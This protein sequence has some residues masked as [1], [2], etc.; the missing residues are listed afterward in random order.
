[1]SAKPEQSPVF[2]DHALRNQQQ[3][4]LL[5]AEREGKFEDLRHDPQG[6]GFAEEGDSE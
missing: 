3:I 5:R 2:D 6:D 4:A 1:M